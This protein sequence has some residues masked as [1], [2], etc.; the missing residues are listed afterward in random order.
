MYAALEEERTYRKTKLTLLEDF[1]NVTDYM[2]LDKKGLEIE[3]TDSLKKEIR[4]VLD[5]ITSF[6][7]ISKDGSPYIGF[8]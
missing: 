5:Y 2:T 7:E 6:C 1:N 8:P 4:K 3:G